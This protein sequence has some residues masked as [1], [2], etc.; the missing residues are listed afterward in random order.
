[1]NKTEASY[2]AFLDLRQRA[3]EILWFKFEGIKFRLAD[4]TFY[5]PDFAIMNADC[6]MQFDDIKG[7]MMEDA[8]VKIKVAA[9]TYPFRFNIVRKGKGAAWLITP[10]RTQDA[11]AA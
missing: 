11:E 10:V 3:G 9:E 6:S 8:N 2:A 5:T 1:M 7:F 4:K